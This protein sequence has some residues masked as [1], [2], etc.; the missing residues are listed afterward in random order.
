M[1]KKILAGILALTMAFTV[2]PYGVSGVTSVEAAQTENKY[3]SKGYVVDADGVEEICVGDYLEVAAYVYSSADDTA[4]ANN[5]WG[6]V[7]DQEAPQDQVDFGNSAYLMMYAPEQDSEDWTYFSGKVPEAAFGQYVKKIYGYYINDEAN[8]TQEIFYT[9][10]LSNRTVH[11]FGGTKNISFASNNDGKTV[12]TYSVF[13]VGTSAKI[14]ASIKVNGIT[15]KVT[16]I[17]DYA[18]ENTSLKS[19]TIPAGVKSIGKE[20]FINAKN[21]KSI[22]INGNVTSVGKNAFKGINK[23]AVIKIKA[24]KANYKKIVSRIKKAGAPKTVTFKNVK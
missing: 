19:V 24:S 22:T 12:T 10:A 20:A 18:N 2:V 11:S 7:P 5:L 21:L 3:Y 15:Y 9:S 17:G 6:F 8:S 23:K 1:K 13:N 4:L 14:P 16:S